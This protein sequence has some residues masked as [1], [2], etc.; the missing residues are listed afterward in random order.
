[1]SARLRPFAAVTESAAPGSARRARRC[2]AR[3][4]AGRLPEVFAL[5]AG[6]VPMPDAVPEGAI[7]A[8]SATG[9]VPAARQP[10]SARSRRGLRR[11]AA[12]RAAARGPAAS[13]SG[14][15]SRPAPRP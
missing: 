7:D 12:M 6:L 3:L 14:R 8:D 10:G 15:R 13:P 5:P 1:M 11:P 4:R 9:A 2:A